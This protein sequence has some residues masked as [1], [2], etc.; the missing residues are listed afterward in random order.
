MNQWRTCA[1]VPGALLLTGEHGRRRGRLH[2]RSGSA[3]NAAVI[4]RILTADLVICADSAA[5]RHQPWTRCRYLAVMLIVVFRR[6]IRPAGRLPGRAAGPMQGAERD[7]ARARLAADGDP[8]AGPAFAAAITGLRQHSTPLPSGPWPARASRPPSVTSAM[9]RPPRPQPAKP[10][11]SPG[12]CAASRC[13][14]A[15]KPPARQAP[16]RGLRITGSAS[17]SR[18]LPRTRPLTRRS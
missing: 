6:V 17:P 8:A 14:T 9:T 1:C 12:S 10:S 16:H 3:E 18:P 5:R 11:A 13:W 7:L 15:R 4:E 2:G